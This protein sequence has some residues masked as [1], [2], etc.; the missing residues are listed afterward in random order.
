[1]AEHR[2]AA[3]AIVGL[4]Q[5]D[6]ERFAAMPGAERVD[7]VC[8]VFGPRD[9]IARVKAVRGPICSECRVSWEDV[10]RNP[11]KPWPCPGVRPEALGGTLTQPTGTRPSR[12]RQER[13]AKQRHATRATASPK[14]D[15][16]K[17]ALETA[18]WKD[19]AERRRRKADAESERQRAADLATYSAALANIDDL[20]EFW[21]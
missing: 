19:A 1:M 7:S 10:H 6:A 21:A 5:A 2:W 4:A 20:S 11:A 9:G 12:N 17:A 16:G 15:A 14:F 8:G 18:I 13:R 3:V